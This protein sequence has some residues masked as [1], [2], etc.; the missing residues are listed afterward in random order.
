MPP[1]LSK[2]L[3]TS[4][5]AL[6]VGEKNLVIGFGLPHVRNASAIA[7]HNIVIIAAQT[8]YFYLHCH[9]FQEL[10]WWSD[11]CAV[12]RRHFYV[13]LPNSAP[14]EIFDKTPD[15][16]FKKTQIRNKNPRYK[17]QRIDVSLKY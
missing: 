4:L 15:Y 8:P 10:K 9:K 13:M 16:P 11:F 12:S 5:S 14:T 17:Q 7:A 2:F 6:V 3:A 1:R